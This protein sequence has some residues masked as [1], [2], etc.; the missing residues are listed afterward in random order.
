MSVNAASGST[1]TYDLNGNMTSDGTNS[2]S[3]DAA[4]R[5]TKI[6]YPGTNNFSTFVYNG[7]SRNVSI[8][9]TT[10]GS[11]T[12]TKQFVWDS[13]ARFEE[14]DA[15]GSVV[16]K[17]YDLAEVQ[18]SVNNYYL[19]D[20]LL[21]VRQLTNQA[22]SVVTQIDYD[23]WGNS[24]TIGTV[25]PTYSY[26]SLY[27][28]QRSGLLI[29]ESRVY[30]PKTSNWLSRDLM[31]D[32]GGPNSY[33]YVSNSPSNLVDS[34]GD[35]GMLPAP[36][37]LGPI[38]TPPLA[39]GP[40]PIVT[41]PL[42]PGPGPNITP[43]L[44]PGPGPNITPPLAPGPGP[45]ITP[46]L[47]P[48]GGAVFAKPPGNAW[49]PNGPKAPGAPGAANGFRH[50]KGGPNWVPNPNPGRGGS[51]HG[52]QDDRG[53][54]WCPTGRGGRAHGGPHWDVQSP[55]GGNTNVGPGQ[56]IP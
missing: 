45:N 52:W 14:R 49:N 21:T 41:P 55:G 44:A 24:T 8:V 29:S 53:R 2:Y 25:L 42:A 15:L 51:S 11:V 54:V 3:W 40:G 35:V 12:S 18:S 36:P 47:A 34:T 9:E 28:H 23:M 32:A 4:D 1:L 38:V 7:F 31:E 30:N 17:L 43:P 6:T 56:R 39:P 26:A 33:T 5:M 50:P 10:A 19:L 46:P 16:K 22:G 20:H 48:S 13:S 37:G 27:G